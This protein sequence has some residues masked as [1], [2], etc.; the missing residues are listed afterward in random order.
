VSLSRPPLKIALQLVKLA[1][2]QGWPFRAVVADN[3]YGED[4]GLKQ[5]LRELGVPYVMALKPSH[6]WYHPEDVA[7]T[8][9]DV[10]YEAGWQSAERPGQWVQVTRTFR[11][12]SKQQWWALEIIAG[13]YGPDKTQRAIVA[14]TDPET[15]PAQTTW[16]LVEQ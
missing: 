9:Q 8:L 7:G 4:R 10:A 13:P 1:V 12:D 14:T 2:E 15:L 3:F 6:A 5:G 11:D 16:Y